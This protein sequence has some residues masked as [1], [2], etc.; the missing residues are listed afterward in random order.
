MLFMNR[1]GGIDNKLIEFFKQFQWLLEG[2]III[3]PFTL[4]TIYLVFLFIIS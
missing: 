4:Q 2:I 3:M 1:S